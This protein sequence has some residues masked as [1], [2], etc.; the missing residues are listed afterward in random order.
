MKGLP[1]DPK[2]DASLPLNAQLFQT[3]LGVTSEGFQDALSQG[4]F[5]GGMLPPNPRGVDEA[6]DEQVGGLC[7]W[8]G[9]GWVG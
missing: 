3:T 1:S 9:G 2:R 7:V 8:C 6:Y 4:I 5:G